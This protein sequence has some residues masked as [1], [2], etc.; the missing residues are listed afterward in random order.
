MVAILKLMNQGYRI[1]PPRR[2]YEAHVE[3][4]GHARMFEGAQGLGASNGCG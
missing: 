1:S 4:L 2:V 3:Q